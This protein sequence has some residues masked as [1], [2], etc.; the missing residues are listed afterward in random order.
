MNMDQ[1]LNSER[2]PGKRP[3]PPRI[4]EFTRIFW[5]GLTE[6]RFLATRCGTCARYSFPPKPFCP[7]CWGRRVAWMPLVPRGTVYS[8]TVIHA[9]PQVFAQEA[10][11]RVAII[12]LVDGVRIATRLIGANDFAIGRTVEIVMLQYDDGPLFAVRPV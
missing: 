3:Y 9:A 10:P 12:D 1:R 4:T 5:E 6:G 2:V 8:S 7:H 11:Y